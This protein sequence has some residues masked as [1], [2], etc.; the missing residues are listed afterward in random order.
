MTPA[1]WDKQK[2]LY[3][4]FP[5]SEF[6]CRHTNKNEMKH[7]F[8]TV[9]QAIRKEYGPMKITSGF[10]HPTHPI[11]ARKMRPGEHTFGMC[12]DVA[13]NNGADRYRL[14]TIALKHGCTRIGIA[15]TFVHIGLGAPGLPNNVIWEYQ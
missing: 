10:R 2:E 4:N 6:D 14:V 9:L 12:C 11:E 3:P 13:C 15:K 8:M 5:K 1:Q 7:E